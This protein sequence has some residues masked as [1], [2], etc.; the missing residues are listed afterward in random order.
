M[1]APGAASGTDAA[2]AWA[3]F[4]GG[5]TPRLFLEDV[6]RAGECYLCDI[7]DVLEKEV[8]RL[9]EE[10]QKRSRGVRA[11]GAARREGGGGG[12]GG[13]GGSGPTDS[14]L[15]AEIAAGVD[16]VWETMLQAYELVGDQFEAYALRNV[17][18]WPEGVE[19]SVRGA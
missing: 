18:Q 6:Y 2:A 17:F 11:A 4:L 8:H 13:G 16:C 1:S 14:S 9:C 5:T 7:A 15:H 19:F 10:Q 3:A 12:G